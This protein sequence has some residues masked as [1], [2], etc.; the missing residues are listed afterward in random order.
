VITFRQDGMLFNYR[1]VGVALSN[2]RVLLH[3][4]EKDNFLRGKKKDLS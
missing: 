1:S 2:N 4:S 3:K